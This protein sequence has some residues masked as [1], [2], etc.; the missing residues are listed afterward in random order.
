MLKTRPRK[1]SIGES[2][3]ISEAV[4]LA[5][6]E[7]GLTQARLSHLS[8]LSVSFIRALEQNTR[9]LKLTKVEE[10]MRFLGL[11]IRIVK[12]EQGQK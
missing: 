2:S 11:E 3:P 5:R 12:R 7:Q 9:A 8:G 4:K 1:R 10:L 6:F